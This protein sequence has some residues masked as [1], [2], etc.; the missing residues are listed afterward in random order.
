M[1]GSMVGAEACCLDES[2]DGG[3]CLFPVSVSVFFA[4]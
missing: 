4:R 2:G 1:I 3:L